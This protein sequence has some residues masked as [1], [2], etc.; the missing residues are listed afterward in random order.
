MSRHGQV[1]LKTKGPAS[2]A[3][4]GKHQTDKKI[5]MRYDGPGPRR[6]AVSFRID[7]QWFVIQVT[8]G[9]SPGR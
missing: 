6:T 7:A 3:V 8:T 1:G 9:D 4:D 2:G 5:G